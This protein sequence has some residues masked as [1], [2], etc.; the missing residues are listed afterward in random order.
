MPDG[1]RKTSKAQRP[2][3]GNVPLT[4]SF[5]TSQTF[6]NYVVALFNRFAFAAAQDVCQDDIPKFNPLFI[7]GPPGLGKTHLLN[8]IGNTWLAKSDGS[9]A[10]LSCQNLIVYDPAIPPAPYETLWKSLGTTRILLV[11]DVHQVPAEGNFQQHLREIFN[12]CYD[13]GTQMVF[14]A[15]RLPHQIPSLDVGLRS[16]LGWGLITRIREPDVDG[17]Y[18]VIENFMGATRIPASEDIC[19]YLT[20]QGPLNFHEIKDFVEK[21]QEIVE[22][23]GSLPN[24]KERSLAVHTN[25]SPRPERLSMQAI[26]KEV[27]DAYA[28]S[29]EALP[30]ATKARPLVIARQVGMYLSRK[31]TGSTYAAIGASFGGRDHSTVIYACRK[32]RAE[33]RR[34]RAFAERIVDIEKRLLE[35]FREESSV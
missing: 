32:V 27:C 34:N 11:D 14:A 5:Q 15:T 9:A 30:G 26:Q 1:Q 29:L 12:W 22:K 33:M 10:Y 17:C 18:Q 23:E 21:L 3:I 13:A 24:L 6:E 31:L 2:F 20:E 25:T 8:A 4:T 19:R 35:V 16:R 28:V 7:E